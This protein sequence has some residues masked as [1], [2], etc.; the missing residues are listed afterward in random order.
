MSSTNGTTQSGEQGEPEELTLPEI[1][2]RYNGK[3]VGV[4]VTARDKNYQ[5]TRGKVV[6]DSQDRYMLRQK[7]IKYMDICIFFAGDPVYPLL[8]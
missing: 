2:K 5:P 1:F 8:L 6:A 3:W 4:L 7:L